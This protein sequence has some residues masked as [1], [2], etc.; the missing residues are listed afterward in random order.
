MANL[1]LLDDLWQSALNGYGL[2]RP[3]EEVEI[4]VFRVILAFLGGKCMHQIGYSCWS[5][6]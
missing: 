5:T 4:R 6:E 3:T 2:V 1:F